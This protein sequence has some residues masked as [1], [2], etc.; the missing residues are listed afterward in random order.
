MPVL[1]VRDLPQEVYHKLVDRAKRERRTISQ[2]ATVILKEALDVAT[3]P[4]ERRAQML[5]GLAETA[6][7]KKTLRVTPPEKLIRED[8]DR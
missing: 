8:R 2:Q 4:K 1:Q 3:P 5:R 6:P 7:G